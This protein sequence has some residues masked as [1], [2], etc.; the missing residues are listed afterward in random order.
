[1]S[2]DTGRQLLSPNTNTHEKGFI[3]PSPPKSQPDRQDQM[4]SADFRD[5]LH[6]TSGSSGTVIQTPH[7][8]SQAGMSPAALELFENGI[9]FDNLDQAESSRQQG[10]AYLSHE[11]PGLHLANAEGSKLGSLLAESNSLSTVKVTTPGST[12]VARGSEGARNTSS[13]LEEKAQSRSFLGETKMDPKVW[14]TSNSESLPNLPALIQSSLN[15]NASIGFF[16]GNSDPLPQE[17]TSQHRLS[18][19]EPR[20]SHPNPSALPPH[21]G[22]NAQNLPLVSPLATAAEPPVHQRNATPGG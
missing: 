19:Q 20:N 13:F 2:C 12:T 7:R 1:M 8:Q 11:L 10:L 9:S 5:E 15:H 14:S 3:D 22:W 17:S 6:G 16:D 18:T 4:A 21:T